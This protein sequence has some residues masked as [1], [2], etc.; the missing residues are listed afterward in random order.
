M[1]KGI[2]SL[3][4]AFLCTVG[5]LHA[6]TSSSCMTL[7]GARIYEGSITDTDFIPEEGGEEEEF[8]EL[9]RNDADDWEVDGWGVETDE[10]GSYYWAS[11]HNEGRLRQTILLEEAGFDEE[12]IDSS[13]VVYQASAM[14]RVK[15][16]SRIAEATVEELDENDNV[17]NTVTVVD[18]GEVRPDFITEWEYYETSLCALTPGTRRLRY[19]VRGQDKLKWAGYYGPCFK[20]LSLKAKV[21]GE[22]TGDGMVSPFREPED[23]AIYNIA[24]Q[25]ISKMQKG[26]NIV[27]DKKVLI[28]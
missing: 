24:G 16:G 14:V 11:S 19:V 9:L 25:R 13:K 8:V 3:I 1:K 5:G 6:D 28:K 7:Y 27:G 4:I 10:D 2:L 22:V 20:N 12:D 15:W 18:L 23:E 17:L 21:I 26:I